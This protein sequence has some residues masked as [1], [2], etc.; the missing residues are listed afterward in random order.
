[1][2]VFWRVKLHCEMKIRFLR[3]KQFREKKINLLFCLIRHCRRINQY[4]FT[5]VLKNILSAP[6]K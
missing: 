4:I 2:N 1:M 5:Q 6:L 3:F